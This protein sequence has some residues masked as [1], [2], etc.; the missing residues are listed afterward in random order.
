MA[1]QHEG[2]GETAF[3]STSITHIVALGTNDM[4]GNKEKSSNDGGVAAAAA[5]G[6]AVTDDAK[7][8]MH[9]RRTSGNLVIADVAICWY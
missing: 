3:L 9:T 2:W 5:V 1:S 8:A 6:R 7:M 4:Q